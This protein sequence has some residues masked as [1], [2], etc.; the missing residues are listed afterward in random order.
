M[1]ATRPSEGATKAIKLSLETLSESVFVHNVEGICVYICII[2]LKNP[3]AGYA[4][5]IGIAFEGRRPDVFLHMSS[6]TL[7]M[8]HALPKEEPKE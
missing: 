4:A 3:Y 7:H 2:C 8:L 6:E 1:H 5:D